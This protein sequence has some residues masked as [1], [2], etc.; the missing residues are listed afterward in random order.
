MP[1]RPIVSRSEAQTI[2]PSAITNP[3]V[4]AWALLG[5]LALLGDA[6]VRMLGAAEGHA[7]V[8][9]AGV[10]EWSVAA[11][12]AVAFAYGEGHLALARRFV[13]ELIERAAT[14]R[15][16]A[17]SVLAP[18]AA[19]GLCFAPRARLIRSWALVVGIVALV[20]AMRLLTPALHA[21][22]DLGVGIALAV[23]AVALV[24]QGLGHAFVRA[25]VGAIWRRPASAGPPS[26]RGA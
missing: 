23:G 24:R 13:P 14:I 6:C 9:E 5:N 12:I 25:S 4:F 26:R 17:P 21:G 8:A 22:V 3:A 15:G 16:V 20:F 1:Q 19:A 11:A 10:I 7:R 2:P 18:L